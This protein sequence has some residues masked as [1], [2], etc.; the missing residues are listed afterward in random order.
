M[1]IEITIINWKHESLKKNS[2]SLEELKE[3]IVKSPWTQPARL[4]TNQNAVAT[5][6]RPTACY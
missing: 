2:E 6:H 3:T 1:S 5:V 4:R